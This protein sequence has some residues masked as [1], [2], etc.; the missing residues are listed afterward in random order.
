MERIEALLRH[1]GRPE[2]S[3]RSV[4]IAGTNGKG[5]TAAMIEAGLRAAGRRTGLYTS[6]HL[7]RINERI[8][9]AGEEVSEAEF[10]DAF[11]AVQGAV[12][13]LLA[14]GG[15]DSH[16]SYFECVTAL[17][18]EHFR[19]AGVEWAVV[20]VG[21]GGRLDATNVVRPE[22]TVITP[23]DFDHE[24]F[25]GKAAEAISAEKAGILKPGVPAVLG[26]QRPQARQVLEG[27]AAELGIRVVRVEEDWRAEQVTAEDGRYRFV[28]RGVQ[29]EL[30]L[31]GEHQVTNALTAIAALD[32]LGVPKE[33]IEQGLRTAQ[34]PGRLETV[35]Q[36]PLVLLDGAHNPAGARAL[37]RFLE[38]H[39]AGSRVWLIYGAMRDKAVD[40]VA[41]IL[42]PA[43]YRVI[44]TQVGQS[45][46]VSA[47]ALA[48]I[49]AHHHAR[50]EVTGSLAEALAQARAEAARTDIIVITGSL[51]LVG[52]A[53]S[54]AL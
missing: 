13:E 43:A 22:V 6:P 11:E 34:W 3:F 24:A 23:I 25:L 1:L 10:A 12:E 54:M 20:E 17:G 21:L 15:V 51:F 49:V 50:V 32:L 44:L 45:R 16:P 42:F 48:A 53:K 52:E 30:S 38:Q 9:V 19:R 4:H 26:P 41:G 39:H 33:A 47:R 2:H 8:R 46:A 40:E 31:A 5:S 29:A 36:R 28:A 18:F 14:A 27:R 35:A 7:V 37:V